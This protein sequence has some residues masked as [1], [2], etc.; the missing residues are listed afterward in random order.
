MP[1]FFFKHTPAICEYAGLNRGKT[2]VSGGL[3]GAELVHIPG[4]EN[5]ESAILKEYIWYTTARCFSDKTKMQVEEGIPEGKPDS[6]G[7]TL[8]KGF[9]GKR[10]VKPGRAKAPNGKTWRFLFFLSGFGKKPPSAY[11]CCPNLFVHPYGKIR[12]ALK[13]IEL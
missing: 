13:I 2:P 3:Q 6:G 12:V 1:D 5:L 11:L 10:R 9:A 4:P 7:K 8:Q